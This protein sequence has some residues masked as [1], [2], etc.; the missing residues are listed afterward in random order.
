MRRR[1][2]WMG[3]CFQCDVNSSGDPHGNRQIHGDRKLPESQWLG[4]KIGRQWDGFYLSSHSRLPIHS[5]L[6][7]EWSGE[8][9]FVQV[10]IV[11]YWL[12]LDATAGCRQ[13]VG[14]VAGS[15]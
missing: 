14:R 8:A 7:W 5:G 9:P 11:G 12:V 2:R 3:N 15:T 13:Y 10:D 4:W 1:L 6:E